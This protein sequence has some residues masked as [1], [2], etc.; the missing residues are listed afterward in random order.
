MKTSNLSNQAVRQS[1]VGHVWVEKITNNTGTL[2]VPK[3]TTFR[4]R[5]VTTGT[6]VKIDGT[7]AMTM[8]AGEIAIFNVGLGDPAYVPSPS[9]NKNLVEIKIEVQ[10]A[11]VQLAT[12][13]DVRALSNIVAGP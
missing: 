12:D 11:F 9:V 2:Y 13:T 8:L 1:E 4:V 5:C 7:L 10:A 6:T 3:L